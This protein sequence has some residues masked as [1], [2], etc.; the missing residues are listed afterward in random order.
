MVENVTLF[1]L[2][3]FSNEFQTVENVSL[4]RDVWSWLRYLLRS[5]SSRHRLNTRGER[6]QYLAHPHLSSTVYR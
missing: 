3:L 2:D 4:G 1:T 5:R 6:Y